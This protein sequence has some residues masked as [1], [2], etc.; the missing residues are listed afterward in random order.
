MKNRLIESGEQFGKLTVLKS[1]G[2]IGRSLVAYSCVCSCG[3]SVRCSGY[4]LLTR[5]KKSCG[6]IRGSSRSDKYVGMTFNHLTIIRIESYYRDTGSSSKAVCKCSCGKL[7]SIPVLKVTSGSTKSCGHINYVCT[8]EDRQSGFNQIIGRY[9]DKSQRRGL[10]LS[11]SDDQ[12]RELCKSNCYYCGLA[13]SQKIVHHGKITLVYN[14]IDRVN[15]DIGYTVSNSVSCCH[16]CNRAKYMHS[17][18]DFRQW[19]SHIKMNYEEIKR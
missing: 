19:L 16:F 17:E 1:D 4:D 8:S 3:S 15:N 6:C 7:K 10:E 2:R 5:G 12:I 13:P 9:K 11:L 18:D 14:G